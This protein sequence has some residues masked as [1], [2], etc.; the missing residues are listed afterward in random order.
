MMNKSTTTW[1]SK[2]LLANVTG[3]SRALIR[4]NLHYGGAV[5]DPCSSLY[6]ESAP[7][8]QAQG[9]IIYRLLLA[10]RPLTSLTGYLWIV[11]LV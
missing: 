8:D 6:L 10:T 9:P 7:L 5:W 11:S 4:I 1:F 2:F 3:A